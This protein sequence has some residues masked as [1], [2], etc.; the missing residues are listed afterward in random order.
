M[1]S[2]FTDRP[3]STWVARNELAFALRDAYPVSPG[4]TLVIPFREVATWFE[5]T[6]EEQMA[7]LA[8]VNVVKRQLDEEL[9]PDGYNVGFNAGLAAGQTVMHLHVHVIPRF[10]GDVPD[11]RGGVRHVIP[12]KG[13]YLAASPLA[14]GGTADPFL[15]HVL[16][17]FDSASRVS[18][19]AA[20][21]QD[22]GLTLLLDAVHALLARGGTV[23]LVTGDYLAITQVAA[24]ER[25]LSWTVLFPAFEARMVE[26]ARLTPPGT[27]FHPKSW[28]FEGPGVAVGFVGSSNISRS[29]LAGGIEWNLRTDRALAPEAWTRL[30]AAFDALWTAATPLTAAWLAE[31]E[32][33]ARLESRPLPPGEEVA[34]PLP[35]VPL[36]HTLQREGL[37]ALKKTRKDGRGRALVVM[38]TGLGKT[39]LAAFDLAQMCREL[40][41]FPRTLFVAHRAEILEQAARTFTRIARDLGEAPRLSWCAGSGDDL[42]G[43][44]VFASVQKLALA[45][46]LERLAAEHFD[47]VVVDEVHHAAA[48]SYRRILN[49]LDTDFLLGL[50][51]TPDRADEADVLGFFDD[52]V[53]Y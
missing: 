2:P 19:V 24:L 51:A 48:A 28:L 33:R 7:L 8:L 34:E 45:D 11:P 46:G 29:A 50:T 53:P 40:G 21:V 15:A 32:R 39:W 44:L 31:Y 6:I 20:F 25:L 17:L 5:A 14:T 42:S 9:R 49:S 47:Y 22:S 37:E 38:A 30:T 43:Q 13:N 4:H 18:L 27:A 36:P 1:A 52:N 10:T 12:G 3:P 16:P 35:P 26:T 23:R 41:R